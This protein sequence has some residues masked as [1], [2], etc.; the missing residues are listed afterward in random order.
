MPLGRRPTESAFGNR[1]LQVRRHHQF[2]G[3]CYTVP[4]ILQARS[5]QLLGEIRRRNLLQSHDRVGRWSQRLY[6]SSSSQWSNYTLP[7]TLGIH[8]VE[9]RLEREYYGGAATDSAWIDDVVFT[10][11]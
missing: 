3:Q 4:R 11:Q 6:L 9:W 1:E 10:G 8:E 7:I 2:A 5:A